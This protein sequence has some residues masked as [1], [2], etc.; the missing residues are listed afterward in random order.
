MSGPHA[1]P[2]I[3][4]GESYLGT[5]GPKGF[6]ESEDFEDRPREGST[7]SKLG[8]LGPLRPQLRLEPYDFDLETDV[9]NG[10]LDLRPEL[11]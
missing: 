11:A 7:F 6:S 10:R 4:S 3:R 8:S 2:V 1:R 5:L 9:R